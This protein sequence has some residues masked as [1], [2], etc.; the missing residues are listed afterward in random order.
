MEQKDE[1]IPAASKDPDNAGPNDQD[2]PERA[3][4]NDQDR[5]ERADPNDQD[6]LERQVKTYKRV[7]LVAV[8]ACIGAFGWVAYSRRISSPIQI[9]LD[10]K[11]VVTVRSQQSATAVLLAAEREKTGSYP[12]PEDA[13]KTLQKVQFRHVARETAV[14]QDDTA[15][16]T[17]A[18]K[19]KI[20][21]RA[22]AILVNGHSSIG[23]PTAEAAAQTLSIV[24]HHFEAMPPEGPVSG[25]TEFVDRVVV[26]RL[27][28][29]SAQLR[30]DPNDAAAYFWTPRQVKTYTVQPHDTGFSIARKSHIAFSDFL[31]ANAG[32][33]LNRLHPGDTVNVSKTTLLIHVLVHKQVQTTESVI[34][35]VPESEAGRQ[36]VT[37]DVTY[38]NGHETKR[39]VLGMETLEKPLTR[40]SL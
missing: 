20:H 40:T 30:T 9:L 32:R 26:E 4:P 23:L 5:P 7:A 31:S 21:V 38:I 22:Y 29:D 18:A 15:A 27:G 33:D 37:Y 13:Y 3:D 17:L 28:L 16:H 11:P 19:L 14:D 24:K 34:S 25:D 35:N 39:R 8:L 12:Y 1:P 10:G 2:R 36:R 6:K